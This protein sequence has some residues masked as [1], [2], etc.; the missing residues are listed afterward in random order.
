ME[1]FRSRHS[2]RSTREGRDLMQ[3]RLCLPLRQFVESGAW[4]TSFQAGCTVRFD[5]FAVAVSH[6]SLFQCSPQSVADSFFNR[7]SVCMAEVPEREVGSPLHPGADCDPSFLHPSPP[8]REKAPLPN[9]ETGPSRKASRT[10]TG[11]CINKGSRD[12]GFQWS[13]LQQ[14]FALPINLQV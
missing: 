1:G 4:C 8:R 14:S 10:H 12:A 5:V 13:S 11:P 9:R 2:A 7:D 3:H 6:A